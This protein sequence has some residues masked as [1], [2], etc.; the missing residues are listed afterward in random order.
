MTVTKESV[1]EK[2][3]K[4]TKLEY[5]SNPFKL[6]FEATKKFFDNNAGWGIVL[7]AIGLLGSVGNFNQS[8]STTPTQTSLESAAASGD[9]TVSIAMI[10]LILCGVMLAILFALVIGTFIQGMF[11]YVAL[12]SLK[13]EKASFSEAYNETKKRFGRLVAAQIVAFFK[14]IGWTLLFIIPGIIASL[15]YSLLSYAIMDEPEDERS[16]KGSHDRVKEITK[17]RLWEVLG[18]NGTGI[19]PIIGGVFSTAGT[20]ALYRQLQ[21]YTDKNL[22]KPKIHWLNYLLLFIFLGFIALLVLIGVIVAAR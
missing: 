17:G 2:E 20:G 14:I 10:V 16:V 18:V 19:V 15:R 4:T 6:A 22:E 7:V 3:E 11:S 8:S 21:V 1:M 12:Q 13:D 9:T 5:I